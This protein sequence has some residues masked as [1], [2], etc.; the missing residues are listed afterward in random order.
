MSAIA[1]PPPIPSSSRRRWRRRFAGASSSLYAVVT[2]LP[3][4]WICGDRV[5]VADGRHRLSAEDALHSRRSKAIVN[6]FT[7][8]TRQT[9]DFIASL[10]PPQ[11]WYDE[12]RPRRATW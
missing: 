5:Q 7:T 1:D 4:V 8:R 10:P 2:I 6:L 11:T 9:P 3:L 12:A